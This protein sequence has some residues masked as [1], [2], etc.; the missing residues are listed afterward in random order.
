MRR[1]PP[2]AFE[3]SPG[4]I[5]ND[6]FMSEENPA[7]EKCYLL[8]D[9]ESGNET[10]ANGLSLDELP[11]YASA[12]VLPT[13]ERTA[14]LFNENKDANSLVDQKWGVIL[15]MGDRGKELF[16]FVAE[17]VALREKEQGMKVVPFEVEPNMD[18]AAS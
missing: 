4:K 15:P 2:I 8:L 13:K 9:L 11:I 7:E 5:K 10:F 16:S 14:Y 18:A 12:P 17:L 6:A 3:L 1:L